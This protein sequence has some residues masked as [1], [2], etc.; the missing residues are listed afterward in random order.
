[1]TLCPI[2]FFIS[3]GVLL[4]QSPKNGITVS[5]GRSICNFARYCQI[6]NRDRI[7]LLSCQCYIRVP[8]ALRLFQQS[9]LL[10]IGVFPYDR[11]EVV[12]CFSFN[13]RFSVFSFSSRLYFF[14]LGTVYSPF[15]PI[16]L[17]CC[18]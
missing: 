11:L 16:F 6:R 8:V 7:V 13:L 2:S 1:M 5:K 3:F 18:C 15:S 12:S 14:L 10:N 9:G 17:L 4:G